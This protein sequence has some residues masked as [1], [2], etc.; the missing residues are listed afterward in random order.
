[1]STT[2]RR[3]AFFALL[4]LFL[5]PGPAA[6]SLPCS[7]CAGVRIA[8]PAGLLEALQAQYQLKPGSPLFVAW[9]VPLAGVSEAPATD[10]PG[11][12]F[13]GGGTPWLSLRFS[14]PAPLARDPGH[15]A[16][17]QGELQAAAAVAR[18]APAGSW[19]QVVWR[20]EG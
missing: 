10:L 15:L 1:M 13:K 17:L 7:P 4:A 2:R 16:R 11:A 18:Q 12:V 8:T 20:P 3:F 6:A 9:E 14:T 19:F 5:L